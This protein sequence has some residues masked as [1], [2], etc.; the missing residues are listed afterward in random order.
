[1]PSIRPGL[2]LAAALSFAVPSLAQERVQQRM[3]AEEFRATGLDTLD[4]AQL[5]RLDAWFAR[6][7]ASAQAETDEAPADRGGSV[8]PARVAEAPVDST[9]AGTFSGFAKGREYTLANGQVWRQIDAAQLPGVTLQAPAV[10]IRPARL[11]GWWMRVG[12]YNT[13]ARVERIR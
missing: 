5:A 8:R 2:I 10:E 3:S 1:M 7:L 12:A 6:Q 11:G 4:P 9:L 13:R